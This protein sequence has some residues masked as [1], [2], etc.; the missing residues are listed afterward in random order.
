MIGKTIYDA[1]IDEMRAAT[2][3]D[4]DNYAKALAAS[5]YMVRVLRILMPEIIPPSGP[6][7]I[8]RLTPVLRAY[9]LEKGADV[10]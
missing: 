8:E 3:E 4:V 5:R 7:F 10:S 6:D 2:Q 9:L 1:S